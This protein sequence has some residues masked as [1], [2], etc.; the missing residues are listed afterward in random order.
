MGMKIFKYESKEDRRCRETSEAFARI[1]EIRKLTEK[2][3]RAQR[4]CDLLEYI[5][6]ESFRKAKQIAATLPYD[7]MMGEEMWSLAEALE[8]MKSTD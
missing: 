5:H 4:T 1:A 8:K 3:W 7:S 2:L 6:P